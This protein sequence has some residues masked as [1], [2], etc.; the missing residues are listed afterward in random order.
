MSRDPQRFEVL[1]GGQAGVG[2]LYDLW[3]RL[4]ARLRGERFQAAHAAD[5]PTTAFGGVS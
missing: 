3:R 5:D 1:H 4:R 2:G